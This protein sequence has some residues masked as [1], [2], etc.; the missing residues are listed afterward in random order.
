MTYDITSELAFTLH[1]M[2]ILFIIGLVFA[3]ILVFVL[4]LNMFMGD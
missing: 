2:N 1:L 4:F 3:G